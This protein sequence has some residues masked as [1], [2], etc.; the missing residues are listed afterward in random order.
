LGSDKKKKTK[1][2][3]GKEIEIIG[4]KGMDILV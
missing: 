1:F 2:D 3:Y 4:R